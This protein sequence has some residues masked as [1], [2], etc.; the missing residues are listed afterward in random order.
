MIAHALKDVEQGNI[1]PLWMGVQTCGTI[2]LNMG[3]LRKLETDLHQD[4]TTALLGIPKECSI[5][6]QRYLFKYVHR[7]FN[8]NSQKI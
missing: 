2:E 3:F 8:F 6:S 5:L 1:P 7:T 4:P